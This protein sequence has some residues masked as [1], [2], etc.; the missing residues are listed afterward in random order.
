MNSK[1]NIVESNQPKAKSRVMKKTIII[2]TVII[3]VT[4]GVLMGILFGLNLVG[5][6]RMYDC[7]ATK[8][9]SIKEEFQFDTNSYKSLAI[10]L[11]GYVRNSSV[12]FERHDSNLIIIDKKLF[13]SEK[14]DIN[15]LRAYY[16]NEDNTYKFTINDG[17]D[18][19]SGFDR[20]DCF[21]A[22]LIVKIPESLDIFSYLGMNTYQTN[23]DL[24]FNGKLNLNDLKLSVSHGDV[25]LINNNIKTAELN[26]NHGDLEARDTQ[27]ES[28]TLNI[29]HGDSSF[30]KVTIKNN[31]SKG[32]HGDLITKESKI[33]SSL[34]KN[35]HG[36]I[37]Y[38]NT[39]L[40]S[41]EAENSHG[42]V[43]I[44]NSKLN[45][46][47][48]DCE[49]GAIKLNVSK[50]KKTQLK[51]S[52]GYI[53]VDVND[54]QQNDKDL[55]Y[56]TKNSHG[57]TLLKFNFLFDN[58]FFITNNKGSINLNYKSN[59]KSI[60]MLKDEEK[61]KSG[62]IGENQNSGNEISIQSEHGDVQLS[63]L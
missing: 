63:F 13:V 56:Q 49:H 22:D 40:S 17:R 44:N 19:V 31:I 41:V 30:H 29:D 4:L 9:F 35:Q 47:K 57:E 34:I 51:N 36:N 7:V 18:N 43:I 46:I 53:E 12:K 10:N 15:L 21:K 50:T 42:D 27:I 45:E 38:Y 20:Y 37:E 60:H 48:V 16:V 61:V 52:H 2:G 23:L 26:I 3:L 59:E 39:T 6:N 25:K 33:D 14:F 11:G 28:N 55:N 24:N 8:P 58:N 54:I 62:Y 1:S 5:S 32:S